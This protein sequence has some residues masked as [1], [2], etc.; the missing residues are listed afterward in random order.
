MKKKGEIALPPKDI[1]SMILCDINGN[2]ICDMGRPTEY[3]SISYEIPMSINYQPEL[4]LSMSNC[5]ISN[6]FRNAIVNN[7][8]FGNKVKMIGSQPY[9]VQK[10]IHKKKRINKKWLKKYG[11]E[12]KHAPFEVFLKDC[13]LTP[14]E[15]NRNAFEISGKIVR[16]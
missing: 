16:E 12:T 1:Y 6:D 11:Y 15:F 13:R 10:K 4:E 3:S 5:E 14:D 7:K 8:G 2:K 9:L